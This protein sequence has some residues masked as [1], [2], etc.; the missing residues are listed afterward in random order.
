MVHSDEHQEAARPGVSGGRRL[1]VGVV[2]ARTVAQGIGAYVARAFASAG[3]E[4]V[5]LVGTSPATVAQARADLSRRYGLQCAGYLDVGAM[6]GEQALDVLAI[7]SPP[8]VHREALAAAL[9]ARVHV[10]CE[11]PLWWEADS[12]RRAGLAAEVEALARGFLERGR[13]LALNT[14]WPA[15]LPTFRR[16]HP[17]AEKGGVR[18]FSMHLSPRGDAPG[19][20]PGRV[21]REHL[22]IDAAPHAL[23]LLRALV[24]PG[25]VEGASA[26]A[27]AP[28]PAIGGGPALAALDL[29]F[30]WRT[31][32]LATRVELTLR[33]CPEQ[34]RP[35]G[36][37]INGAWADRE[38]ELP[39]YAMSLVS[40]ES[41]ARRVPLPDPLDAHVADFVAGVAAGRRT[42]VEAL[43]ESL[44]ALRDLVG[45]AVGSEEAA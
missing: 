20:Q 27:P 10:L 35:A 1:R 19:S 21:G 15:T 33:Q 14:Q 4:V 16:L 29:R 25:R 11:K 12:A 8:G 31:A 43:V 2:G 44:A 45:V 41:P 6:L 17:Q 3:C 28:A 30:T 23:S 39:S 18:S 5:A 9:E 36:Y 42:D 13:L 37:A 34:P 38:V 7:C 32:E 26:S 24:G 22:V 40:R